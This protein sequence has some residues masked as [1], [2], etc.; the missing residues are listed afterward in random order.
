M[1][2][3][4]YLSDLVAESGREL[5]T[6]VEPFKLDGVSFG[7]F[8]DTALMGVINLSPDSSY[9]ETVATSTEAAIRRGRRL[10]ADGARVLDI[11][12][13]STVAGR[14]RPP[15]RE[16]RDGLLP[17]IEGLA[18]DGAVVSVETY[19]ASLARECL[20]A[21]ARLINLT[22]TR[23][24]EGIYRLA[25]EYEAGV[26]IC[27]LRGANPHA[28]EDFS[29]GGDCREELAGYFSAEIGKAR[30]AGVSRIWI[31]PGL[32]FTYPNLLKDP[33]RR[34]D[35]QMKSILSGFQLRTL[36]VPVCQALP[37]AF[38][39]FEDEVRC[40]EPFYAVLAMLGRADMLRTH[41]VT[42]VRGVIRTL[43][44]FEKKV[45]SWQSKR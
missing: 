38:D 37:P 12:A 5:E 45:A 44:A 6:R 34:A 18:G 24:T 22:S 35:F 17:V 14:N 19:S 7:H 43:S 23:D 26:I 8:P 32:T 36:G 31:D 40:G 28:V 20:Q 2:D 15:T 41:E 9:R 25:G 16:Q 13:E 42:K 39:F 3:L 1:L 11:G 21:G 10:I 29:S 4:S 30:A 27:F 33:R